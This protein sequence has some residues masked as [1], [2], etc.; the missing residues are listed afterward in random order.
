MADAEIIA[1]VYKILRAL[2][3][4]NFKIKI[5]NRKILEGVQAYIG[6]DS[7]M[8]QSLI[9]AMDKIGKVTRAEVA[10]ELELSSDQAKRLDEIVD[11]KNAGELEVFLKQIRQEGIAEMN[12]L[13]KN[14]AYLGV[15]QENL[16]F[17]PYLARGLSY[18]TGI[19]FETFLDDMPEIGSV[20]SGGRY[21]GL[22]E[23]FSKNKMPAVGVSI[24]LDRLFA[25][26][27]KLGRIEKKSRIADVLVLNFE[28]DGEAEAEI[29]KAATSLRAAEIKTEIYLG[30][31]NSFKGQLAY[32]VKNEY[33]I[34]V[35][36]GNKELE[37]GI[38]QVKDMNKKEQAE[39]LTK[40]LV[41]KIKNILNV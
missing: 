34:V 13:T 41:Q 28:S 23:K 35:I 24:G 10:R 3:V 7:K 29:Q 20:A 17:S 4:E 32:A 27:E 38:I 6:I 18:Y 9:R 5:N 39:V 15:P 33:P 25:A 12:E 37:R 22:I 8:T 21:D 30:S 36:I 1:V 40:D 19:V 26:L 31:E 14:L 16:V 2:Q 11:F